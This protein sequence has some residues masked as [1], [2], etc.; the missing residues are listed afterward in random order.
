MAVWAGRLFG[1]GL[2]PAGTEVELALELGSLRLRTA[3][4]YARQVAAGALTLR[5]TGFNDSQL[6]LAW[7]DAAGTWTCHLGAADDIAA[8]LAAWPQELAPLPRKLKG[9]HHRALM[10]WATLALIIALPLML[11]AAFLVS[12][13]RVVDF[14]AAQISRDT[15]SQ[16]GSITLAQVRATTRFVEQGPQA[17]ALAAVA[18]QVVAG[19]ASSYRFH[20]ADD[21]QVNAFAVPGGDIVVYRGLLE[22]TRSP[23]ELAG[24]L[25]HEVQHVALRHSLKGMI[26]SAGLAMLWALIAGDPSSTLFGRAGEQLLTLKLS[27]DAER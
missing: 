26:R 24:V 25:A 9:G 27:R 1:P 10:S 16:I 14:I 5:Y 8:L 21:K 13:D 2:P 22:A 18:G 12:Q 17:E 7:Q 15:E 20:L 4:E 19:D 11:L 3:G 23:E 6:D